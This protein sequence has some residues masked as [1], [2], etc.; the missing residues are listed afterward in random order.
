MIDGGR[1]VAE[2]RTALA[3]LPDEMT[4]IMEGCD[5]EGLWGGE[6]LPVARDKDGWEYLDGPPTGEHA[7]PNAVL[8]KR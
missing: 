6:I 7:K 2:L 1:S 8:L 3:A 5:C 4:V